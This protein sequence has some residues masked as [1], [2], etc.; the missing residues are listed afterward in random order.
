MFNKTSNLKFHVGILPLFTTLLVILC[1][2]SPASG[3]LLDGASLAPATLQDI[4][5]KTQAGTILILGESHGLAAHRD[6]HIAVMQALKESGKKVSVGLEFIN[7]TDQTFVDQYV[8]QQ[9]PEAEFL[10]DIRWQGIDFQFYKQQLLFSKLSDGYSLGINLPRTITSKLAKTGLAS[11]SEEEARLLPPNFQL[12][13]DTYKQRFTDVIHVPSGPVLDR[14][15]LAQS[16]WDDT[17]AWQST[18]FMKAHPEQVLVIVVGEFHAQYGGGLAD[19]IRARDTSRQVV[20]LSQINAI[21]VFEDGHS[22][23][24][25]D[26]Q[27]KEELKVSA[28]EGPRGDFIWLSKLPTSK[29][30]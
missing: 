27:L 8:T 19:R 5:S 30:P 26:E 10:K 29:I 1:G 12:G 13:R 16:A 17:M 14:Y 15:F 22:E 21:N 24:F 3:Q 23:N 18:E 20:V 7:Y 6:Q 28:V 2:S 11:L 9:L 25:S 4:V